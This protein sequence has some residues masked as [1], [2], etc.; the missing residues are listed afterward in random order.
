LYQIK[1]FHFEKTYLLNELIQVFLRPDQY[2]LLEND[3]LPDEDCIFINQDGAEDLNQIKRE[4]FDKLSVLTGKRP[5]WGILTGVRPVKLCGEIYERLKDREAVLNTLKTVYY[6]NQEKAELILDT[7]L[8]QQ[9]FCGRVR[10][11]SACVY[12]GIPFCPTRCVYCSFASNQVT[13]SEIERY[14]TALHKEVEFVGKRMK[15][16]GITAETIYIGGGQFVHASSPKVGTIVS[17]LSDSYYT[18]GFVGGRR[19]VGS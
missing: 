18:T 19:I 2:Q 17:N 9:E 1:I 8:H 5:E 10:E 16:T 12:V 7:Y 15:E 14:L 6:L 11:K 3:E 4:I 13:D